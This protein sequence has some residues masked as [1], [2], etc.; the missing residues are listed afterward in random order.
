MQAIIEQFWSNWIKLYF[1][2]LVIRQKWHV[3]KR[4]VQKNDICVV[5]DSNL[6][7]GEWRIARVSEC[8][9]DRNGRVR[10]VELMVKPRQ[11]TSAEYVPTVPIYIRRHVNNLIVL[12]PSE[13][14]EDN[15]FSSGTSGFQAGV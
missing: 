6:L 15:S 2:S 7:R 1:P 8:Y 9:P 3:A 14:V 4:N 10:N 12:V 5:K 13:D 11:G